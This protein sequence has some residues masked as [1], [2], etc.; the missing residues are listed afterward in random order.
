MGECRMAEPVT[1]VLVDE[2][3]I[4]RVLTA[5]CRAVDRLDLDLA[6]SVFHPGATV[7]YVDVFAGSAIDLIAFCFEAHLTY[8]THSHQLSN[9]TVSFDG[10]TAA[11]EAY[12][13][14]TLRARPHAEG[15]SVD[16]V[17]LGRYLDRWWR[18]GGRWAIVERTFVTDISSDYSVASSTYRRDENEASYSSLVRSATT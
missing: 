12:V 16:T 17:V 1:D 11:S 5:Y 14:A 6:R 13:T 3:V 18:R 2:L 10:G 8:Q 7:D 4:R 15:N 9:V